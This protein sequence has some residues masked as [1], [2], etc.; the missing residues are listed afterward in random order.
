MFTRFLI[1][2]I[3]YLEMLIY[4]IESYQCKQNINN[5]HILYKQNGYINY[6]IAYQ[7]W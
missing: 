7:I 6:I 5:V 4:L 2:P 3:Y 1:A